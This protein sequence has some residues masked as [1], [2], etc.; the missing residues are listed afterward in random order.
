MILN[1]SKGATKDA[2]LELVSKDTNSMQIRQLKIEHQARLWAYGR[3]DV[4]TQRSNKPVGENYS[5]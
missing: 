2:N 1:N 3:E 4:H 5:E